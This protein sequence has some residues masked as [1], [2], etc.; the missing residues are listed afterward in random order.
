MKDHVFIC[1]SHKDEDF[2][3]KLAA[4][5]KNR[6]VSI[7]L[8]QWDI[9]SGANWNRAIEMALK[10]STC[11]LLIL[12]SSSV[13]SDEVQC[14]WLSAIDENKVV[15]PI[16]YQPCHIPHRL[17]PIQYID[18]TSSGP[19]DE[20]AVGKILKTLGMAGD[21]NEK[22]MTQPEKP[23]EKFLY[24]S[25]LDSPKVKNIS[26][27]N[28]STIFK[29][30]IDAHGKNIMIYGAIAAFIVAICFGLYFYFNQPISSIP[31][32]QVPSTQNTQNASIDMSKDIGEIRLIKDGSAVGIALAYMMQAAI[33]VKTGEQVV[34]SPRSIYIAAKQYDGTPLESDT[35][36][37]LTSALKAM[38][39]IGAYLETD[40]PISS[41]IAPDPGTLPAYR[42]SSYSEV[43]GVDGIINAMKQGK[44]VLVNAI[45][46][47][48]FASDYA[49]KNGKIVISHP[50][51]IIG[52]TAV[53]LVGYDQKLAEFKFANSW[54]KNWGVNGFGIIGDS[55]LSQ[56]LREAY[57]IEL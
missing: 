43:K 23:P 29:T 22:L 47:D 13:E 37:N 49:Q 42:I 15:I 26:Y 12:S 7:W 30:K 50:L 6:G 1:Y 55:D 52:G 20:E 3:L 14:E 35:G 45:V 41:Q 4:N 24:S 17:K 2:V 39:K 38:E 36:T 54:G 11:V 10:E 31:G 48:D 28:N 25:T 19:D 46:T 53:C 34:L 27:N 16:L 40:W 56:I 9:P 5:L 32:M 51:E 21:A 57:T 44:V 8:D 18:F 33:K